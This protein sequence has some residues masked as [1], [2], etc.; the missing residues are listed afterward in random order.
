MHSNTQTTTLTAK[1]GKKKMG[2]KAR[3]Q[4][5][6]T[7]V[8]ILIVVIILAILAGVVIPQFSSSSDEAK[9]SVLQSDLATMRGSAELYYHQHNSTYPGAVASGVPG[10]ADAAAYFADQLTLYT[11]VDGNAAAVKTALIKYGP[12]IKK[13]IPV[14][15]FND[16][17]TVEVD[18]VVVDLTAAA[19]DG[20]EGWKFYALTG[21]L[22]AD[23][24]AHDTY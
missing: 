18:I 11:D 2:K 19:A 7:L 22:F 9:L 20:G 14:N 1:G 5:G 4:K 6:F 24:G 17:N 12:Y 15:P 23:D 13:G 16:L 10:S 21:Q 3:N 8:E